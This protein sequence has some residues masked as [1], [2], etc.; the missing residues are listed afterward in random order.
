MDEYVYVDWLDQV[1]TVKD[2]TLV[3][4]YDA[5]PYFVAIGTCGTHTILFHRMFESDQIEDFID[6]IIT[7]LPSQ[8][9][10]YLDEVLTTNDNV[11]VHWSRYHNTPSAYDIYY[12]FTGDNQSIEEMLNWMQLNS[13]FAA[14]NYR[15]TEIKDGKQ[16]VIEL[17]N[18]EGGEQ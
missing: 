3:R 2:G 18:N 12:D 13:D 10:D 14:T 16:T 11:L 6:S 9:E 15:Y 7:G 1:I 8:A 5:D 4:S 17:W